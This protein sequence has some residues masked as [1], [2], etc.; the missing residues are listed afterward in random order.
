MQLPRWT[1]APRITREHAE[2]SGF[3]APLGQSRLQGL[4]DPPGN[5]RMS[6]WIRSA[7]PRRGWVGRCVSLWGQHQ[8][9]AVSTQWR[10]AVMSLAS[11][12]GWAT[13]WPWGRQQTWAGA[14][15]VQERDVN[16]ELA[17]PLASGPLGY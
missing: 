17:K 7:A 8:E 6:T 5:K 1:P 2:T 14:S 11:E 4:G 9:G 16:S 12:E 3:L 10:R 15:Q 13:G